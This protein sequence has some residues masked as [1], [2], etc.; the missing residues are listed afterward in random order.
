MRRVKVTS[1]EYAGKEYEGCRCYY[2]Y[3]HTGN[4]PDLFIIKTPNGDKTVTSLQIDVAHYEAQLL[5]EEIKRLGAKVGDVVNIVCSG[6][7]SYAEDWNE[8]IP[9]QITNITSNGTV[10]FDN[11]LATMFRPDVEIIKS[12]L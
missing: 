5:E 7:G 3:L 8:N 1:G 9:H 6:S 12:K 11:G 4:S 10:E 2:D